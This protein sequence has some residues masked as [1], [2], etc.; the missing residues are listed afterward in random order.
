MSVEKRQS[1]PEIDAARFIAHTLVVDKK[2]GCQELD[3]IDFIDCG[4]VVRSL[5]LAIGAHRYY[6]MS[7]L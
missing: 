6:E 7:R 1:N 3:L 2:F 5:T 4:R